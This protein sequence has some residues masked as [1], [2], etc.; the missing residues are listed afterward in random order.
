MLYFLVHSLSGGRDFAAT[1]KRCAEAV[2]EAAAECEIGSIIYLSGLHPTGKLS[3]HLQSRVEVGEI[4][5]ASGVSGAHPAG[6][7]GD[8]LRLRKL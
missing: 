2:G 7:V 1:D 8:R 6:R 4:L 5:E 3:P